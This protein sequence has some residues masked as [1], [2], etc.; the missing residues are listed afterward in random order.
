MFEVSEAASV[1]TQSADKDVKII[2]GAITDETLKDEL[3]ITV[4]ATG[5]DNRERPTK[6]ENVIQNR[7]EF[8]RRNYTNNEPKKVEEKTFFGS[9]KNFFGIES[10]NKKEQ[11]KEIIQEVE[12]EIEED[13]IKPSF[14]DKL[15][16]V[17]TIK[18]MREGTD[19]TN[20]KSFDAP[21]VTFMNDGVQKKGPSLQVV[22]DDEDEDDEEDNSDV[23]AFLRRK[24]DRN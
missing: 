20:L 6:K 22:N 15:K 17:K 8:E 2:F 18:E 7:D 10:E 3:R 1:I 9:S 14:I 24:L 16:G 21:S 4:I 5:F 12:E 11:T 19:F 23:P 13:Q